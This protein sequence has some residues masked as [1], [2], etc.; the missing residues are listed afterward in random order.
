MQI[1]VITDWKQVIEQQKTLPYWVNLETI[2]DKSYSNSIVYPKQENIFKCFNYFNIK[3]TKVVI[4]GQDPYPTPGDANGLAFSV[5]RN[6]NLPHSLQ[7]I[8]YELQTDLK[9]NRSMGNLEDWAK[10]GVLLL[11]TALTFSKSNS[12]FMSLWRPFTENIIKYIDQNI[13][14][15]VFVLWGNFAK[16]FEFLIKNNARYIIK[17][18]HPSFANIHK[19]FFNTKPFSKTNR[20]LEQLKRKPINW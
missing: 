1:N 8:F 5:D 16:Q 13:D 17:S 3:D 7:N 19:L 6:Y 14:G 10:Q 12:N 11:N 15:V 20:L 18:G 4:L 2:V 9:I